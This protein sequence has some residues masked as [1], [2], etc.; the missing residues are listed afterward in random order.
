VSGTPTRLL[1][2]RHLF[3]P[4][5]REILQEECVCVVS[6]TPTRL[7]GTRHLC[8]RDTSGGVNVRGEWDA[9]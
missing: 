2:T 8:Q 9:Y 5:A 7:L 1:G 4:F 3:Q 6:G